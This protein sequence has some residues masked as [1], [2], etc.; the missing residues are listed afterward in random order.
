MAAVFVFP[1]HM[2]N[3]SGTVREQTQPAKKWLPHYVQHKCSTVSHKRA[4]FN[5]E[6]IQAKTQASHCRTVAIVFRHVTLEK[7]T[8]DR[9]AWAVMRRLPLHGGERISA[10]SVCKSRFRLQPLLSISVHHVL[11]FSGRNWQTSVT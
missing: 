5:L 10:F 2:E 9:S 6:S 3:T 8:A 11:A 7:F 1:A 4:L